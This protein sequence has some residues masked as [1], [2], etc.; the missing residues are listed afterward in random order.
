[1]L[2]TLLFSILNFRENTR[3]VPIIGVLILNTVPKILQKASFSTAWTSDHSNQ[4]L[5]LCRLMYLHRLNVSTVNVHLIQDYVFQK[6]GFCA[7]R[8]WKF[9]YHFR[10]TFAGMNDSDG[11]GVIWA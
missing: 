10:I 7:S 6:K 4:F 1:M 2:L 8:L 3:Q 9:S 5:F 11:L